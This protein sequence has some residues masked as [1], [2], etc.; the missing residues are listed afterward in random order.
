M[1]I[2]VYSQYYR[3]RTPERQ[4]E[5][6]ECLRINLNH[7]DISRVIL[8]CESDA[9]PIP[10]GTVPVE[11]ITSD[12]RIT[13]AE[14]FRWVQRQGS[15]IGLLL[16]A[17]IHLDREL[18]NQAS[19]F[20]TP[21]TFIVLTCPNPGQANFRLNDFNHLTKGLWSTRDIAEPLES[22]LFAS[23]SAMRFSGYG[24]P[25]ACSSYASHLRFNTFKKHEN[26][27]DRLC[28]VASDGHPNLVPSGAAELK[29]MMRMRLPERPKGVQ[30]NQHELGQLRLVK[31]R[32]TP[33]EI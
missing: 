30:I 1:D 10:Q 31:T 20:N 15:G 6:D 28:S 27:S 25:I 16:N 29:F 13:Y 8:F 26:T 2:V 24:S 32:R 7:A 5:I 3:T 21:E 17:D 11:A 23:N 14:W 4:L 19:S 22:L 9:P 18:E 12:E 33:Q